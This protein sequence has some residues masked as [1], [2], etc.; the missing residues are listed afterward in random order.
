MARDSKPPT[1]GGRAWWCWWW[2]QLCRLHD[3]G[4][5]PPI[6]NAYHWDGLLRSPVCASR[7][8]VG[9]GG[10]LLR[11]T[12]AQPGPR[13]HQYYG[14]LLFHLSVAAD[15]KRSLPPTLPQVAGDPLY[16]DWFAHLDMALGLSADRCRTVDGRVSTLGADRS[17]R[18]CRHRRGLRLPRLRQSRGRSTGGPFHLCGRRGRTQPVQRQPV[19]A[20]DPVLRLG[21]SDPDRGS[22]LHA[23]G[24]RGDR[25]L[26]PRFPWKLHPVLAARD[27]SLFFALSLAK[28]TVLP[29]FIG[30][31]VLVVLV[32]LLRGEHTSLRRP[33]VVRILLAVFGVGLATFY[34]GQGG[35]LSLAPLRAMRSF[36][37]LYV[38][39]AF[40]RSPGAN[41]FI[42]GV[43]VVAVMLVW[44]IVVLGRLWGVRRMPAVAH[45]RPRSGVPRRCCSQVWRRTC[46]S[47]IPAEVRS[48]S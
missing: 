27:G 9:C 13:G 37:E 41:A 7:R 28:S 47:L 10:E 2:W 22:D 31:A 6:S 44:C 18:L 23:A 14:D 38:S 43:S 8:S 4:Y 46:C 25:R 16:D 32:R 42:A 39:S 15:A 19:L 26:L 48:I 3:A 11:W 34:G 1:G 24:C 33:I 12:P 45:R 17:P 35:G 30:G 40:E 5:Q 20:D 36:A 29:V 21:E